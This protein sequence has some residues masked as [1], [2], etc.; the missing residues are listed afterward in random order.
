MKRHTNMIAVAALTLSSHALAGSVDISYSRITS[1]SSENVES[2]FVTTMSTVLGDSSVIDFIF[3][4]NVGIASS[5][6]EVYF[7]NGA[8]S[9]LFGSGFI[10][11]QIGT[12]FNFGS[13][14]PGNLPGGNSMTEPFNVTLS[15]LADAQGNPTKGVSESGDLLRIRMS[16][17]SGITFGDV[18]S[19]LESGDLR[20][21]FHV[22][23]IGADGNSDSFVSGGGQP[24]IVPL[25]PPALL[26]AGGLLACLSPRRRRSA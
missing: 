13:A 14:N 25:P 6:S 19:A 18:E 21:G 26:G 15:F 1:N 7:D 12:N 11:E 17:L 22:R 23:A 9:S 2:Q 3:S 5:I 16:L 4:N 10:A 24:P 8:S 20:L